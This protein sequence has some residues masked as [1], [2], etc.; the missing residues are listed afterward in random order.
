MFL[1]VLGC[2]GVRARVRAR[3][4]VSFVRTPVRAERMFVFGQQCSLPALLIGDEMGLGKT[5]QALALAAQY[6]EEWPA[7]IPPACGLAQPC[8]RRTG[9]CQSKD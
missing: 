8:D 1:F 5:L 7:L 4:T 2:G 6:A 9:C 3:A